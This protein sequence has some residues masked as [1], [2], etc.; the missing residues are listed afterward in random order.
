MTDSPQ[1]LLG[2]PDDDL[3][4]ELREKL[5]RW[6]ASWEQGQ[7]DVPP[8][9]YHYTD[10]QGLLGI[11]ELKELWASNAAFLNDSTE[12]VYIK[13]VLDAVIAELREEH[14]LLL[15]NHF[16]DVVGRTFVRIVT[17]QF[18]IFLAC[19]CEEG[20]QL[21]QWRGYPAVGGGY[22]VGFDGPELSQGRMLGKVIYD[23]NAQ[24]ELMRGLLS[25]CCEYLVACWDRAITQAAESPESERDATT[26]PMAE[27]TD[28]L[29]LAGGLTAGN[30]TIC[31]FYF[32]HPGFREEREWRLI[33]ASAREREP[34]YS[35]TPSFRARTTG[36]VP[37]TP[38]R[39]GNES[40]RPLAEVV[41]GPAAHPDL[42]A[43]AARQL[44]ES[45][46]YDNASE[47]VRSSEIPLRV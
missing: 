8:I 6:E 3:A 47:I 5:S 22:A 24:Q 12:L 30:V 2:P 17:E 21:S 25:P 34:P 26:S 16:L 44:L 38:V 7:A 31:S 42:A 46:G 4:G 1:E 20:D 35:V 43:L 13:Q 10:A 39:L 15:V 33:R 14:D 28:A 27:M 29:K 19:F 40:E 41:V 18:E 11:V 9:L 32:K 45:A 36:L 37:Y 23:L